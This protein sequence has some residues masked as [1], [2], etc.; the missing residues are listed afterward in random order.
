MLCLD[1]N[2]V[3]VSL[4]VP[5]ANGTVHLRHWTIPFHL[6]GGGRQS[7][8]GVA[9][10]LDLVCCTVSYNFYWQLIER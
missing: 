2:V 4:D 7:S 1:P 6:M 9:K 5:A 10:L 3:G 8:D